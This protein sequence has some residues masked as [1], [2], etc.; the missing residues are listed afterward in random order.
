MKN[1]FKFM[2]S[3]LFLLFGVAAGYAQADGLTVSRM[4]YDN[5]L[6]LWVLDLGLENPDRAYL[7]FQC[8]LAFPKKMIYKGSRKNSKRIYVVEDEFSDNMYQSHTIQQNF[9]DNGTMRVLVSS[10]HNLDFAGTTGTLYTLRF[11]DN[12]SLDK[13]K[14]YDVNLTNVELVYREKDKLLPYRHPGVIND[15][16]LQCFDALCNTP[17]VYGHISQKNLEWLNTALL[18]NEN[19]V[20]V[21]LTHCTDI[22][23]GTLYLKNPNAVIF[24]IKENQVSGN[25]N[26]VCRGECPVLKLTDK[27]PFSPVHEFAVKAVNYSLKIGAAGYATIVL[28]FSCA[29][30]NGLEA[31]RISRVVETDNSVW[32]EALHGIE[33]HQPVLLKGAPGTY[34]FQGTAQ[35]ITVAP[36]N[37]ENGLLVGT[38]LPEVVTADNYLLQRQ[39][40]GVAFYKVGATSRPGMKPFRAYLK[41]TGNGVS[42]LSIVLEELTGI[43]NG[44][45][46]FEGN[47]AIYGIGGQR[48]LKSERGVNILKKN[49]GTVQKR[50]IK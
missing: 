47:V 49:D 45:N 43:E 22:S 13:S 48:L 44:Q 10:D 39:A 12:G 21:D 35:T 30:P 40:N 36:E 5:S 42:L 8:D 46:D 24:T 23:L 38:Y 31:Y 34:V 33:A 50:L 26:V 15:P 14:S 18:H 32:G 41:A 11:S 37:M 28:P 2:V 9:L 16:S 29:I 17:S 1:A 4:T 6:N 25:Q 19:A 20:S 7:S 3:A 27:M